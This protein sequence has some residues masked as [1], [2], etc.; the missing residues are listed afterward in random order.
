MFFQ[1]NKVE[2]QITNLIFMVEGHL[3]NKYG[4]NPNKSVKL[5]DVRKA[6]TEE[7]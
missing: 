4:H 3:L 6:M 5:V 1:V 7:D 2:R